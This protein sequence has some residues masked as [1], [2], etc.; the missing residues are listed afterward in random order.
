MFFGSKKPN[1]SPSTLINIGKMAMQ[2][3]SAKEIADKLNLKEEDV[4][5]IVKEMGLE[6]GLPY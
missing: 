5:R 2:G 1:F 6:G 3:H 4:E